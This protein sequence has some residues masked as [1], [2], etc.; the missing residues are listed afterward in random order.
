MHI[1]KLHAVVMGYVCKYVCMYA[2]WCAMCIP[3][4]LL[5][6]LTNISLGFPRIPMGAGPTV[7]CVE[8]F[9]SIETCEVDRVLAMTPE[10]ASTK[11]STTETIKGSQLREGCDMIISDQI[12]TLI[13]L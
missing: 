7:V 9:L 5:M 1:Y 3:F 10:E 11:V 8:E 12:A 6:I 13:D 2:Y 4:L